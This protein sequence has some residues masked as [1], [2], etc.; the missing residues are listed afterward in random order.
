MKD[1]KSKKYSLSPNDNEKKA[2][3]TLF[4]IERIKRSKKIS[5][6]LDRY[7]QKKCRTKKKGCVRS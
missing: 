4:I 6:R 5:D 7:G 3:K 2:F 1:V